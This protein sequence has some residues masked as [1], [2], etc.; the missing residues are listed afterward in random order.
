MVEAPLDLIGTT[1]AAQILQKDDATVRRW[2]ISGRLR[3]AMRLPGR[4]G[5]RLFHRADVEALAAEATAAAAGPVERS[6]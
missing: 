5:A 6:A 4:T 2:V 1:E 3:V